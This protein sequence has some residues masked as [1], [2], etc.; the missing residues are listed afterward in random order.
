MSYDVTVVGPPCLDL[1]FRGVPH[2]PA[3]GEEVLCES[4]EM[5]PGGAAISAIM[6]ARLGLRVA[7]SWPVG[8]DPPGSLLARALA[9][10]GVDWIGPA[11]EATSVTAAMALAGERAMV[12][13]AAPGS[14]QPPPPAR[15]Q[16]VRLGDP[17]AGPAGRRYVVTDELASQRF[18]SA[19]LPDLSRCEALFVN[20][21]EARRLTGRAD[22]L[23]AAEALTTGT[24]VA[25]AI[26]TRGPR[27]AVA[28]AA[29][30]PTA[31]QV[32]AIPA[33][34][35]DTTGAGDTFT[36][37]YVW[38]DLNGWDMHE[39]LT[40]ACVAAAL[41]VQCAAGVPGVPSRAR[42]LATASRHLTRAAELT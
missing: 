18:A 33:V 17:I 29:G 19:A 35:I 11:C 12:T 30:A 26:V 14:T 9:D 40:F 31:T 36:G 21:R 24:G 8:A 22:A 39:R 27:G 7:V 28:A 16:I 25:T 23:E 10:E 5:G 2:L 3:I 20:E 1:R 6:L 13:H 34:A 15:A 38:A 37:A 32:D 4:L 41:S 42:L